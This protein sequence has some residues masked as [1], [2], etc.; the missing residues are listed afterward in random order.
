MQVY[1]QKHH[2]QAGDYVFQNQNGGA[3]CSG[4]FRKKMLRYCDQNHIQNGE[5]LFKCHDYR[6]T[7]A[8]RF[9]DAGVPLQT[10][11]D[12]LGHVYEEMTQ[13]YVDYMP[14]KIDKASAE[15]FG[16]HGSL[17]A[18]LLKKKGGTEN[19]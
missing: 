3:Y 18:G 7:L 13:Q 10:I 5:Y 11:R 9:Y 19:G 1:M 15:Y 14:R 17:A 6:H 4:T 2:I 8:T 12:Y 16:R